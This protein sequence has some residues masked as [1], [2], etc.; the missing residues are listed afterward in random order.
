MRNSIPSPV[1]SHSNLPERLLPR[2]GGSPPF[3]SAITKTST[4]IML[5]IN[6]LNTIDGKSRLKIGLN[7]FPKIILRFHVS[8]EFMIENYS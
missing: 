4:K 8:S 3:P 1:G 2:L 7:V 5:E 6:E